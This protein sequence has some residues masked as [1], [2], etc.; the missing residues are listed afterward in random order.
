VWLVPRDD[1]AAL[2]QALHRLAGDPARRRR[3]SVGAQ[4]LAGEFRWEKIAAETLALYR[5][6]G[7]GA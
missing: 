4:A 2:V 7:A 1:V 5:T 3:L 6:L